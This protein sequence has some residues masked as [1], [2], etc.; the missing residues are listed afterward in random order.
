MIHLLSGFDPRVLRFRWK[1]SLS[2]LVPTLFLPS[3]SSSCRFLLSK[4]SPGE[5]FHFKIW[6][7]FFFLF[8]RTKKSNKTKKIKKFP[9]QHNLS[10]THTSPDL[11]LHSSPKFRCVTHNLMRWM[12]SESVI[13]LL[14]KISKCCPRLSRPDLHAAPDARLALAATAAVCVL[15][16]SWE[17]D[18]G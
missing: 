7:D 15:H 13:S 18:R 14:S 4:T 10:H 9:L 3:S 12:R 6:P 2:P 5:I 11:W 1:P 16:D 17:R 8:L